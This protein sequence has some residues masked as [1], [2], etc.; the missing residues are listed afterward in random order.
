[1]IPLSEAHLATPAIIR[2]AQIQGSVGFVTLIW[3]L[4]AL[5]HWPSRGISEG[6][7]GLFAAEQL[8]LW[9]LFWR[10]DIVREWTLLP[11][12]LGSCAVCCL[13]GG[14]WLSLRHAESASQK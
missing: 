4:Y 11:V 8:C 9:L 1:M 13:S 12:L 7:L 2:Y 10:F 3:S 14:W 5:I 6:A